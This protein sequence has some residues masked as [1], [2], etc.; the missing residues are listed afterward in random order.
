MDLL[1]HKK[2]QNNA[3][4]SNMDGPR[5]EHTKRTKTEKDKYD[6]TL[7]ISGIQNMAQMNISM[8]L[9]QSHRENRRGCRGWGYGKRRISSLGLADANLGW[10]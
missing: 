1:T 4:C 6:M 10:T 3:I 7:I 2:E 8:K 5:D 9:T